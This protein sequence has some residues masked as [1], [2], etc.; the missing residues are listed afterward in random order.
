MIHHCKQSTH[1]CCDLYVV[2][3]YLLHFE[4]IEADHY[5]NSWDQYRLVHKS[6]KNAVE[7]LRLP[8][9][10]SDKIEHSNCSCLVIQYSARCFKSVMI[11]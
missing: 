9:Y 5:F 2:L 7:R 3:D 6:L 8:A 1:F 11:F 10:V 4:C